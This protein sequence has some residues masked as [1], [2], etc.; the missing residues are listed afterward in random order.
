MWHKA[1][2]QLS[3]SGAGR[4]AKCWHHFNFRFANMLRRVSAWG[5]RCPKSVEAKLRVRPTTSTA[6][7][8]GFCELPSQIN[9]GAHSLHLQIPPIPPSM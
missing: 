1:R 3:Q 8:P 4:L 5:I 6:D 9:S 2:A 7:R